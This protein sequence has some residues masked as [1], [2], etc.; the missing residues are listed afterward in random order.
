MPRKTDMVK[1][2]KNTTVSEPYSGSSVAKTGKHLY[3][4]EPKYQ[5][6]KS[7]R[8]IVKRNA[9]CSICF[10]H[11]EEIEP[12]WQAP[13]H[14]DFRGSIQAIHPPSIRSTTNKTVSIVWTD[15]VHVWMKASHVW[16]VLDL[17]KEF[18]NASLAWNIHYWKIFKGKFTA[19][20]RTRAP[21]LITDTDNRYR[22]KTLNRWYRKNNK[23]RKSMRTFLS[24]K[25]SMRLHDLL[26]RQGR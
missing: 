26:T 10:S 11:R 16:V 21:R 18:F 7:G 15:L 23:L 1:N 8:S 3:F 13:L 24:I 17:M 4:Q 6:F 20:A 12:F 25:T 19:Q 14:L 9:H 2:N 5:C 22:N